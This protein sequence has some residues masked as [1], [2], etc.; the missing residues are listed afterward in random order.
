M[1]KVVKKAAGFV[2]YRKNCDEII[3]YL[4]MQASYA[5]Y[6]W[7]PPKGHLEENESNMDAAIRETDEEAS[8]KL[9]DLCVDHNFEKVL[10]YDP[11]DKPF[12]KQVTY[13]L[14]RLIN[15]DTPVVLSNEHQDYKWLPLIEA[16]QVAA[17]PEMQELFDDCE[18]YLI[19]T[20]VK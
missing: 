8:I 6:H 20:N 15:P 7:T 17:Y 16:K 14:A 9:K 18:N 10:K 5:N 13:W 12:S 1:S 19:K 2:V 11:K 4:L 3:E